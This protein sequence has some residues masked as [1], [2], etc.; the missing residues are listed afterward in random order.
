MARKFAIGVHIGMA[1]NHQGAPAT[2]AIVAA[3]QG[4]NIINIDDVK[5]FADS[6][7]Q[8]V[9]RPEAKQWCCKNLRHFL[10]REPRLSRSIGQNEIRAIYEAQ[11]KDPPD[12]IHY[13]LDQN[14][15]LHWFD[16]GGNEA[17]RTAP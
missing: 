13:A 6:F 14:R 3:V 8:R 17:I 10:S 1:D 11:N 5:R 15:T 2:P 4:P 12:W 16:P 9:A 7:A